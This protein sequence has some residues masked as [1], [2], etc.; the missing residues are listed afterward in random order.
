[1]PWVQALHVIFMVS[2]FAGLFYLPRIFVYYAAADNPETKQTLATMARKLYKFVT[3]FLVLT[4]VF[5][6]WRLSY[7][8][9]YYL[10]SG[11]MQ[12]KLGCVAVLIAYHIQCGIYMGRI[13]RGEDNKSHVFYRFFNEVP[14]LFLFAII[15][16]VY[17][18]PF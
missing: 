13:C 6:L 16:L 14:V 9:D 15:L 12:A 8:P 5:G 2:W 1:M 7:Q 4:V 18:R 17:T 10:S 11:W 3:P